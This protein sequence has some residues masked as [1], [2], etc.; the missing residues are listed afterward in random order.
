MTDAGWV[1]VGAEDDFEPGRGALV[2]VGGVR[3]AVLREAEGWRAFDDAC[4][5]EGDPLHL[6]L[7]VDGAVVCRNHGWRFRLGDGACTAGDP[8]A[9]LPIRQIRIERGRVLVR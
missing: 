2:R 1:D 9:R 8:A 5:H 4:P 7:F 3:V 6:G